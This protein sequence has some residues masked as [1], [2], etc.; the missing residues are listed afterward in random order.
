MWYYIYNER[1]Q[2][3]GCPEAKFTWSVAYRKYAVRDNV[4]ESKR[5]GEWVQWKKIQSS[6]VKPA[7][8]LSNW[9]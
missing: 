5:K 3:K 4:N 6:S 8:L 7:G 9:I 2:R 1:E